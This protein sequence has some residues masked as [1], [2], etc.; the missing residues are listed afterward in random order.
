MSREEDIVRTALALQNP[1]PRRVLCSSPAPPASACRWSARRPGLRQ[2]AGDRCGVATL[3]NDYWQ[4]SSR[5]LGAAG[6]L[7]IEA[8]NSITTTTCARELSQVRV[9]DAGRQHADQHR[10]RCRQC[11]WSPDLP[12]NSVHYAA[13]WEIR[14][15]SRRRTSATFRLYMT[16]NSV[17]AAG[18]A[19]A[20]RV[21]RR[22]G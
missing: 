3:A 15:G 8:P 22:R 17:E 4:P 16:A 19:G 7:K 20:V 12:E 6:A 14:H 2:P 18:S 5:A 13:L 21:D 9:A 10:G 1:I 11:R